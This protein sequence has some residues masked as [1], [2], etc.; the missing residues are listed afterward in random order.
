V[1]FRDGRLSRRQ[2]VIF[3]LALGAAVILVGLLL[4]PNL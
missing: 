4:I 1:G 2:A 3:Y